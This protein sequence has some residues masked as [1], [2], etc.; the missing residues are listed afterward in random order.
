MDPFSLSIGIAGILPLIA[1]AIIASKEYIDSV[2]TAKTSIVTFVIELEALQFNVA[3]LHD[4]L[5]GD[6]FNNSAVRFDKSSVLL[7]CSAACEAKLRLICEKMDQEANRKR[8]RFLWPFTEKEHQKTIQEIRNFANWM[9]FALS[10]DGCRLL[11]QTSDD[12]LKL[13]RQQLEQFK[14]VQTLEAN[15]QQILDLVQEQKLTIQV[16]IE[17]ETR[18]SIL[19]WISTLR[20]YQK[21][22][23]VQASRAKSTGM[24]ILQSDRFIQWRDHSSSSNVLVC[25]GIQGSGKTNL[26]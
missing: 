19:N 14:T 20:H 17:K 22:Q 1:K 2:R 9:K 16:T 6:A 26:A 13:M 11:S 7:N 10:V 25:H 21:H 8:T 3:N 24:W 15:T 23:L 5:K 18:K 12:V 4:L